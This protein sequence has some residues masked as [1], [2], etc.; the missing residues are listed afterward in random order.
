MMAMR[1]FM[2][3]EL[4]VAKGFSAKEPIV[5]NVG[6]IHGGTTN[7]IVPDH[8]RMFCTL[9][10]WRDSVAE[11]MLSR[12]KAI[13]EAVASTAGGKA[14]LTPV[15]HYPL[16]VN[17][18]GV[19]AALRET[20]ERLLGKEKVKVNARG[21][22]G[23]DFSYF[24]SQKPGCMFRL[25]VKAPGASSWIGVHNECFN[26]DESALEVGVKTFL[27]FILDHQNGLSL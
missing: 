12:I 16:V 26:I 21:M 18:P 2:D 11:G 27:Q 8:C 4:V 7:N 13:I 24:T 20:A 19:T 14:T 22:G 3:I 15:K 5:F 9:R 23:E 25:G 10:T 17:H 1:A 6:A